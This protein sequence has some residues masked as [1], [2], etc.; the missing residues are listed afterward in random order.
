VKLIEAQKI[1]SGK[2]VFG[3]EN[4]I[5][6]VRFMETVSQCSEAIVNCNEG[7]KWVRYRDA[8][9][10]YRDAGE[11]DCTRGFKEEVIAAAVQYLQGER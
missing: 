3:N 10:C 8:E 5:Q 4:Q 7:H 2:L 6:A 11:C 1:L 9:E